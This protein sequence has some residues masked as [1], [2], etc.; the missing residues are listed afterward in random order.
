MAFKMRILVTGGAGF[1]GSMLIPELIKEGH[2][3]TVLD[4]LTWGMQGLSVN[5][6]KPGFDFVKG[7]VRN[8]KLISNLLEKKDVVVHLAALVGYSLCESNKKQAIDVNVNGTRK[9]DNYLSDDQLLIYA[10]TGSV[11]GHVNGSSCT[12]ETAPNPTS[13]YGITK[14]EGEKIFAERNNVVTLRFATAFGVSFRMRLDLL[15]NQFVYEAMKHKALVI[16]GKNY[17]RSVIHVQ[18]IAR[19]ILFVIHNKENMCGQTFNVGSSELTFTKEQIAQRIR[20]QIDCDL[21]FAGSNSDADG[22]N[23]RLSTQKIE[24]LGYRANV[25]LDQGIKELI[26]AVNNFS[27]D[28]T[29]FNA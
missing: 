16:Y 13:H 11:Y 19:S 24:A 9:I 10:S 25:S 15:V 22:R 5:F 1:I 26:S 8:D 6:G 12:E 2:E 7:D 27:I 29:Y 20:K 23:Y 14:L 21:Q 18:D 17:V 3:V 28:K 4:T